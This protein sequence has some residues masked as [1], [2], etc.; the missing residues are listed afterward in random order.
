MACKAITWLRQSASPQPWPSR[1]LQ[2]PGSRGVPSR[3]TRRAY[4]KLSGRRPLSN[5]YA[6]LMSIRRLLHALR[7]DLQ[8]PAMLAGPV[9]YRLFA[10]VAFFGS[11][12]SHGQGQYP[13]SVDGPR[14]RTLPA[15]VDYRRTAP[16]NAPATAL[17]RE[18]SLHRNHLSFLP[19]ITTMFRLTELVLVAATWSLA[20]AH[21]VLIYPPW[22]GNNIHTNGTVSN[23][24][25]SIPPGSL[26]INYHNDTGS[27]GFPYGMQW[28]YPCT[29]SGHAHVRTNDS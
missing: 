25:P 17:I 26:G 2:A 27:Y 29:L 7:A 3:P 9:L 1:P 16:P 21:T 8:W 20:A 11:Q 12:S 15:C 18:A 23:T 10:P 4:A 5:Q 22:R 24:D 6:S 14:H 13:I 19:H 28:M